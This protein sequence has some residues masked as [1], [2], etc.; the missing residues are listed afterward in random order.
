MTGKVTKSK[1][2]VND[3]CNSS[4]KKLK[5]CVTESERK[6]KVVESYPG[7]KLGG[8]FRRDKTIEKK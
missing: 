3:G 4:K 2:V 7:N 8:H 1:K 5:H 6:R